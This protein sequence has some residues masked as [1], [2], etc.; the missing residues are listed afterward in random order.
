MLNCLVLFMNRE[1]ATDTGLSYINKE[2]GTQ[3][4]DC[5]TDLRNS[6]LSIEMNCLTF[7]I[8][9][10]VSTGT[11]LFHSCNERKLNSVD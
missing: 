1:L 3:L 10:E 11:G 6:E 4:M 7:V 8:E 9:S 2:Q 5:P